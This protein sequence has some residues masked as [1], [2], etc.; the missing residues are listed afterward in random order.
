[1]AYV[2]QVVGAGQLH[3]RMGSKAS[4]FKPNRV[5]AGQSYLR[6]HSYFLISILILRWVKLM[7]I[8]CKIPQNALEVCNTLK[9]ILKINN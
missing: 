2:G 8:N 4:A 5:G 9:I 1:M 6:I 7:D 3:L